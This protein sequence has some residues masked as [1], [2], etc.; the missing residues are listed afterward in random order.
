MTAVRLLYAYNKGEPCPI[1]DRVRLA[2]LE[3]QG[4]GP[5]A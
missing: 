2:I 5:V 1:P 4:G 3:Q